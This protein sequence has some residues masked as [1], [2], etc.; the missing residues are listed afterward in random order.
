M[1]DFI[2]LRYSFMAAKAMG[3]KLSLDQ[4]VDRVVAT[5]HGNVEVAAAT[6]LEDQ[7]AIVIQTPAWPKDLNIYC[8]DDSPAA[9]RLLHHN[10]KKWAETNNVGTY[11]ETVE[12][13]K[14]FVSRALEDADIVILDQNLE[15]GGDN[16][17]L[18]TDLVVE[19]TEQRF[20]GLICMRSAN[21]SD[22]DIQLYMA[23]G[24]HCVFGKEMLM[25]NMVEQM[26]QA[27]FDKVCNKGQTSFAG[28]AE[29]ASIGSSSNL[30]GPSSSS[31]VPATSPRPPSAVKNVWRGGDSAV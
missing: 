4:N 22:E 24:A 19:L 31:R 10:L 28:P 6:D 29:V 27:Y 15:Y 8:I 5:L 16:N 17:I 30:P 23:A 13:V 11:G 9:L 3:M 21:V 7:P 14:S 25:K 12:D 18:G 26:K 2:G 1:S 20:Q